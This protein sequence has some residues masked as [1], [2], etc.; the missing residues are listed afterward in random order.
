MSQPEYTLILVG[1][2]GQR[3]GLM[4]G[5]LNVLGLATPPRR[6]IVVDADNRHR[7]RLMELLTFG[8]HPEEARVDYFEPFAQ[9]A[10]SARVSDLVR[11]TGSK[12]WDICM[13]EGDRDMPVDDGFYARPQVASVVFNASLA[14]PGQFALFDS[15]LS[16]AGSAG[17]QSTYVIVGSVAGGTGAGIMPTLAT[18]L[19]RG[20]NRVVGLLFTRY[21]KVEGGGDA[22][23]SGD[24]FLPDNEMLEANSRAGFEFI[25][26]QLVSGKSPFDSVY[27]LGHHSESV[28]QQ[29][30]PHDVFEPHRFLGFLLAASLVADGSAEVDLT[31]EKEKT[32]GTLTSQ[33]YLFP[34]GEKGRVREGQVP[35]KL[36]RDLGLARKKGEQE[37]A[38]VSAT[39][40]RQLL[41]VAAS[42]LGDLRDLAI[43]E[44][45]G[46]FGTFPRR[47]LTPAIYDTLRERGTLSRRD[48]AALLQSLSEAEE[49]HSKVV[50]SL[51]E[52][53]NSLTDLELSEQ[54]SSAINARDWRDVLLKQG[55]KAPSLIAQGWVRA[56]SRAQLAGTSTAS[57]TTI[58]GTDYFLPYKSM[59][60]HEP[61]PCEAKALNP[62]I[63]DAGDVSVLGDWQKLARSF[64]RPDGRA[65]AFAL[66]VQT[67][68]SAQQQQWDLWLGIASGLIG[69]ESV[70]CGGSPADGFDHTLY[71]AS[72]GR[73]R[74]HLRLFASSQAVLGLGGFSREHGPWPGVASDRVRHA[75]RNIDTL[76]HKR[77]WELAAFDRLANPS[78]R[79]RGA[80]VLRM[81]SEDLVLHSRDALGPGFSW[82]RSM[83]ERA[84]RAVDHACRES[85]VQWE[86]LKGI[87]QNHI[88]TVGPLEVGLLNRPVPL[89]LYQYDAWRRCRVTLLQNGL[90]SGDLTFSQDGSVLDP[91]TGSRV[92]RVARE[93]PRSLGAKGSLVST[94]ELL[95]SG[96]GRLEFEGA[97]PMG[98]PGTNGNQPYQQWSRLLQLNADALQEMLDAW[99]GV[100]GALDD[101]LPRCSPLGLDF[102]WN[103]L[104]PNSPG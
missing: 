91:S 74:F 18:H 103:V 67:D 72:G 61:A 12:F 98:P 78:L 48:G 66:A 68:D 53:F 92:A 71:K 101:D 8:H 83:R 7:A 64:A 85:R 73:D 49:V 88:G 29:A 25:R 13:E 26:S 75:M 63:I 46:F 104:R 35:V 6:T 96:Y 60:A 44:A 100:D 34:C 36:P 1:G 38:V 76:L 32:A 87:M 77:A 17:N 10:G 93:T 9:S 94:D 14:Q 3:V 15:I 42:E 102:L 28:P 21:F 54:E 90:L 30:N 89:Y 43:Q 65:E 11:A 81:W 99:Q 19:K 70:D 79:L 47:R 40:L 51:R 59:G 55:D 50:T 5:Y 52:W 22:D 24:S 62:E 27:F 4:L 16:D 56:L 57:P 84:E 39:A 95:R 20:S 37:P 31:A 86:E 80:V 2:T 69:V 33:L 41:P 23:E 45:L 82:F 58:D 97:L